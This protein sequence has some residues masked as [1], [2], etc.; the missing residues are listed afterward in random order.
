V[1]LGQAVLASAEEVAGAAPRQTGLGDLQS[2]GG[3]TEGLEP[4]SRVGVLLL[5]T[6]T[7]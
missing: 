7:Q 5:G 2:V 4:H 1:K 6:N 3:G